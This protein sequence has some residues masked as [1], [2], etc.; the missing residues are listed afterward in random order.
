MQLGFLNIPIMASK[1]S[2][3]AFN[4]AVLLPSNVNFALLFDL[5]FIPPLL[6]FGLLGGLGVGLL[7]GLGVGFL[8]F[9][10]SLSKGLETGFDLDL[11]S[12]T[13]SS[14]AK[15]TEGHCVGGRQFSGLKKGFWGPYSFQP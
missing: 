2:F 8:V 6:V 4:P 7:S 1:L 10:C 5:C 3:F 9:P 12:T 14:F 15:D 13:G 11:V